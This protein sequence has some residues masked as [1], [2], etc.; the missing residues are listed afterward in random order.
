[1]GFP[2]V[3]A[4]TAP[5]VQGAMI[6]GTDMVADMFFGKEGK[7][8][9]ASLEQMYL[10]TPKFVEQMNSMLDKALNEAINNSTGYTNQSIDQQNRSWL[11]AQQELQR[12]MNAATQVS[13]QQANQ[14]LRHS[15]I[16]QAP[17]R[18]VGYG[19]ADA[20]AQSLG[21]P[22]PE[23][24]SQF[25]VLKDQLGQFDSREA[26]L[27][28]QKKWETEIEKLK[29]QSIAPDP[30]FLV[31]EPTQQQINDYLQQN[32]NVYKKNPKWANSK[33]I[34]EYGG[35]K[36]NSAQEAF[37]ANRASVT[38][39]LQDQQ[40]QVY[41]KK[42]QAQVAEAKAAELKLLEA[43]NTLKSETSLLAERETLENQLAKLQN[44]TNTTQKSP[45]DSLSAFQNTA[46]YKNLFGDN[47]QADPSDRFLNSSMYRTL[48]GTDNA[49]KDPSERFLNSGLYR[50]LFGNNTAANPIDRFQADP[51]F[52]FN[53]NRALEQVN[54]KSAAKGLLESG[55]TQR[56]LL[57]TAQGLQNNEYN[58]WLN[59]Q[60]AA[61]DNYQTNQASALNQY[62]NNQN[63]AFNQY[64][65][66]L[67]ALTNLGA[68]NTGNQNYVNTGNMLSQ[69]LGQ[70]QLQTGQNWA[71]N[72]MLSGQNI[73][74]LLANQG[75]LNAS[76]LLNTAAA[77]ANNIFQG[78]S[79]Y[80]QLAAN[81]MASAS[82]TAGSQIAGQGA[83][84]GSNILGYGM[85]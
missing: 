83:Q 75:S 85:G 38:K 73:S 25:Q 77:R 40:R 55:A 61:Y 45:A 67:A 26:I 44:Q 8:G 63:Q 52:E 43:N 76:A 19:A 81:A 3:V 17:Y 27:E 79:L 54:R 18:N 50:T 68:Q 21:I 9:G 72:A 33:I 5:F 28:R 37:D 35:K 6:K 12:S 58:N 71:Q 59:R 2:G 31:P 51:A 23:G 57:E 39:I 82:K 80:A 15:Q 64:Q 1:M 20:L 24:G 53:M 42:Y 65:G 62:T 56:D 84:Q 47:K 30:N 48:Y 74:S 60:T 69:L 29:K 16:L 7:G 49:Q 11:S 70:G 41:T 13:T 36:Y 4:A 34:Y 14:G 78:N 10:K 22:V 46:G 66:N 32:L